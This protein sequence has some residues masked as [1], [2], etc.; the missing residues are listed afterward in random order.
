[1]CAF[2][3]GAPIAT[4]GRVKGKAKEGELMKAFFDS[5]PTDKD[6]VEQS[7]YV[8][9]AIYNAVKT[10]RRWCVDAELLSDETGTPGFLERWF[11]H[12]FSRTRNENTPE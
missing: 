3:V 2:I 5:L 12:L 9:S 1:M 4:T 6:V 8:I 10:D 11:G 7:E